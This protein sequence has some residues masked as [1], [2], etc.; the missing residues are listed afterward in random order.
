MKI[1]LNRLQLFNK[2]YRW[3]EAPEGEAP[4]SAPVVEKPDGADTPQVENAAA[5]ASSK[6]L[7]ITPKD[8]PADPDIQAAAADITKDWHHVSNTLSGGDGTDTLKPGDGDE[9]L[10]GTE[11][12]DPLSESEGENALPPETAKILTDRGVDLGTFEDREIG[13]KSEAEMVAT[14]LK[15]NPDIDAKAL[16]EATGNMF[17]QMTPEQQAEALANMTAEEYQA[18]LKAAQE[19]LANPVATEANT[20]TDPETGEEVTEENQFNLRGLLEAAG[21]TSGN[22]APTSSSSGTTYP[23]NFDVP[24]ISN[25]ELM[26]HV[27]T[28]AT[29]IGANPA[30]LK[31]VVAVE[32]GGDLSATRYEA[33]HGHKGQDEATS[34]GAFQIM[35]FNATSLGYSSATAMKEAFESGGATEQVKAFGEFL[36]TRNL[37]QHIAV[38]REPNFR[39]FASG[40]NGTGYAKLNYHGK[41]AAAYNQYKQS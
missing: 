20:Y 11:G 26:A 24:N 35:G 25:T 34:F 2:S 31:A 12:D 37:V 40:Y 21:I 16:V 7:S 41:M 38:N 4:V 22:S 5:V 19:R 1:I 9:V 29:Q 33:H 39:S 15:E 17:S 6:G 18:F 32:S 27:E 30:A 10:V 13:G 14:F 36:K 3:K 8:L 23:G 28:L